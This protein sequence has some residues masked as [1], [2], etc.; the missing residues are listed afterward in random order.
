MIETILFELV[1]AGEIS[2][3]RKLLKDVNINVNE[4]V[5]GYTHI[6]LACVL[7]DVE[8]VKLFLEDGRADVNKDVY[9]YTPLHRAC[10]NGN[11][12][13]VQMLLEDERV[14]VN[15]G[16]K[17]GYTALYSSVC[18]VELKNITIIESLLKHGANP[19]IKNKDI[20]PFDSATNEVKPIMKVCGYIYGHIDLTDEELRT[21]KTEAV[22][23]LN[24][25]EMICIFASK[26]FHQTAPKNVLLQ[27]LTE[28]NMEL[29]VNQLKNLFA[30]SNLS[31]ANS[32]QKINELKEYYHFSEQHDEHIKANFPEN[33]HDDLPPEEIII[34]PPLIGENV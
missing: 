30:K 29:M 10:L 17:D 22:E 13:I 19:F 8:M 25:P 23:L 4:S 16:D 18:G 26:I 12:K 20:S 3:V 5:Y 2:K 28:T 1:R 21:L 14:D 15:K 34:D 33:D 9:G 24:T 31:A 6:Y 7:G 11:V 27:A 32:S